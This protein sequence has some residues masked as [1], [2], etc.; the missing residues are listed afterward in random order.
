MRLP[1]PCGPV[2]GKQRP[3][4]LQLREGEAVRGSNFSDEGLRPVVNQDM[5]T[6]WS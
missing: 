5:P 3:V 1:N 6:F 4:R 2:P